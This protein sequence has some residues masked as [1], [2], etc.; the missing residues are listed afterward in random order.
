MVGE[1]I[2][3]AGNVLNLPTSNGATLSSQS[4]TVQG[5]RVGGYSVTGG[6]SA[7]GLVTPFAD[8]MT[9]NITF[10]W[11]DSGTNTVY[12]PAT[13]T[14]GSIYTAQTT[15]TVNRPTATLAGRVTSLNPPVSVIAIL[16]GPGLYYGDHDHTENAGIVFQF[17]VT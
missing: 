14:D 6:T 1:Q 12:Y 5:N 15:F 17:D 8:S 4:W 3:L 7:L 10:Y 2:S 11:I 9:S 16:V 13:L